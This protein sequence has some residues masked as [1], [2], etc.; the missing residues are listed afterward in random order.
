MSFNYP[1]I[2]STCEIEKRKHLA[3]LNINVYRSKNSF[4]TSVQR[5]SIFSG[6]Y[7][8]YRSFIANEY[9]RSL[10][11]ALLHRSFTI[12]SGYHKLARRNCKVEISP[13]TKW[14]SNTIL[15]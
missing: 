3:F 13:K 8:K 15:G 9:K 12:T 5:K 1:N 2:R 11:S 4:E 6:V 7:T 10:V 14:I